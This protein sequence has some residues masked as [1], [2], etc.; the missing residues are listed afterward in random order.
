M[1]EE[2]TVQEKMAQEEL[3]FLKGKPLRFPPRRGVEVCLF[4]LF[5]YERKTPC[6]LIKGLQVRP[7]RALPKMVFLTGSSFIL[8][9]VNM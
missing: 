8:F 4:A 1:T 7:L 3:G 2:D 6:L 9:R 5:S